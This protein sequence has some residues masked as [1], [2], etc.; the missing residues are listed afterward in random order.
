MSFNLHRRSFVKELD[1]TPDEL[2]FLLT[3]SADLK[4]A[5]YGGY[6]RRG[7]RGKEI[8]LIFETS[9]TRTMTSFEAA[10][11]DQGAH[12]TY[13]GPAIRTHVGRGPGVNRLHLGSPGVV[14]GPTEGATGGGG[15]VDADDNALH[16]GLLHVCPWARVGRRWPAATAAGWRALDCEAVSTTVRWHMTSTTQGTVHAWR[17]T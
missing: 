1:F 14:G 11:Y 15:P 8:A 16:G 9:S 3:L 12:V 17:R 5:K 2:R 6:Q 10:A 7:L 4:G 13:L